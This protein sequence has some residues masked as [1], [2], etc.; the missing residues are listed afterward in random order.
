[1]RLLRFYKKLYTKSVSSRY[2]NMSSSIYL[3]GMFEDF[4]KY[5]S[6]ICLNSTVPPSLSSLSLPIIA[7]DGAADTLLNQDIVP[8]FV[9]G[10]MDSISEKALEKCN[11][12]RID[13]QETTDFYKAISFAKAKDMMPAII[14]GLD[15]GVLDH[16]LDN[17]ATFVS[18]LR[19]KCMYLSNE[20]IGFCMNNS[21]RTFSVPKNTKISVFG[22][23]SAEVST[24]GL[25]WELKNK[26]FSFFE[27]NSISNRTIAP[28]I[29][30]KVENGS[31]FVLIYVESV[32]DAGADYSS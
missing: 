20:T 10:D 6:I 9:V 1:M 15:G 17:F 14:T 2:N 11:V 31:V 4:E 23:P 16:S 29:N 22:A 21:E 13:D 27:Y 8:D 26:H 24:N 30:I 12:I 19:E 28:D 5:K 25:K 3:R 32:N 18:F 7:T